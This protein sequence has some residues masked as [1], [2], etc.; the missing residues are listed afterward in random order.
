MTQTAVTDRRET[1]M[2]PQQVLAARADMAARE[3]GKV[4]T[5]GNVWMVVQFSIN[6]EQYAIELLHIQEI[7]PLKEL[8]EIPGAPAFILGIVNMRGQ[9]ISVVDLRKLFDLPAQGLSE[10]NRIIVLRSPQMEFGILADAVQ[11]VR[12]IP[13]AE[14]TPSLPTLT[15]I[16]QAFLKA[17]SRD[18][19]VILDGQKMLSDPM[20]VVK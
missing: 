18:H 15:G 9:I 11:G 10:Q 7:F 12:S 5:E 13:E 6:T 14:T 16:R 3:S 8:T 2:D 17:I 20:M 1:V 19:T 4:R